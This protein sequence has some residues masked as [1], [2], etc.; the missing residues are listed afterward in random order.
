MGHDQRN[1]PLIVRSVAGYILLWLLCVGTNLAADAPRPTRCGFGQER[2]VQHAQL[3]H[4]GIASTNPRPQLPFYVDSPT[5]S[6]RV[7]FARTGSDAV[8]QTDLDGSGLEDYVEETIRA[9]DSAFRVEVTTLGFAV[10]PSDLDSGG[11]AAVDIYLRNLSFERETGVYGVTRLETIMPDPNGWDRYTAFIEIDNDFSAED[12]NVYDSLVYTRTNGIEAL[13]VTCAH[14]LHHVIQVGTYGYTGVEFMIYELTSTWMEQVV[15]PEIYDWHLHTSAL[16]RQPWLYEFSRDDAFAGYAWGWF[17]WPL[18]ERSDTLLRHVWTRI[19]SGERPFTAM[20]AACRDVGTSLSE[21]FCGALPSLYATGSRGAQNAYLAGADQLP[22]IRYSA[23]ELARPPSSSAGGTLA[24]FG[25]NALRFMIPGVDGAPVSTSIMITAPDEVALTNRRGSSTQY[26]VL[27][28]ASPLATD[29]TVQGST[30]GIRIDPADR[31][32]AFVS[33]LRTVLAGGPYPQPY[34]A[35]QHDAL[36]FPV[37]NARPGDAA[38]VRVRSVSL[39]QPTS[40]EAVVELDD[41]RLVVAWHDARSIG[42]G[43]YIVEIEHASQTSTH[44]VVIRR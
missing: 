20:V 41:D 15:Y 29:Q 42:T 37:I 24:A 17:G 39:G 40:Y 34:V 31:T 11:S 13:R 5:G 2:N 22:E 25:V 14:E 33:G 44:K 32:C 3:R 38:I 21:I 28:T 8:P 7:H 19:S 27:A 35:S 30:W 12:R 6:F 1:V 23:D 26:N 18:R 43:I 9:L 10:P 16:L 4:A 36:R